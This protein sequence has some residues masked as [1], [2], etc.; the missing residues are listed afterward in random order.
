MRIIEWHLETG[1]QGGERAGEIAVEDKTTNE[2]IDALVRE[3]VF[4]FISWGWEEKE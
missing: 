4:N 1:Q 2:E 3:E